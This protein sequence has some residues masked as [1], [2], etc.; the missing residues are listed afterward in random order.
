MVRLPAGILSFG[1]GPHIC[2]GMSLFMLEAKSLLAVLAREYTLDLISD[3]VE[4]RT[5]FTT[6]LAQPTM[7]RLSRR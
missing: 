6:A 5:A 4:F 3:K 2:L 1:H 7:V